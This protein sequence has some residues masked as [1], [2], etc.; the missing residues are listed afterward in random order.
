MKILI[1][2]KISA[3][4]IE[5]LKDQPDFQVVEAF[6]SGV[7][8]LNSLA[9]DAAAIIVRSETKVTAEVIAE[10]HSLKV[11]AR[12][13][14]GVDN[15]DI[16]AATQRGIVVMNA[17]SGNTNATAELTFTH[18]LC[19][20]RP[21][22]RADASM[23][24]GHWERKAFSGS[25]LYGKT[26]GILGLGRVGS[27]VAERAKAFGMSVLA[28]DPY[29]A[30]ERGQALDVESVDI[31]QLV[32]RVDYI[33][34]H[35]PLTEKTRGLIDSSA[36]EKMKDGVRLINCARGG[37]VV[38]ADLISA[39][40][41]GKIASAGLDVYEEEPVPQDSELLALPNL[42]LTPHLGASTRE[43]QDSVGLEVARGVADLLKEGIIRNALNMSS[44]DAGV[45]KIL[46]PYL[47]LGEKLGLILQQ[48]VSPHVQKMRITFWGKI[49]EQ[50]TL[51]LTRSIQRGYLRNISGENVND[52][53]A[54]HFMKR[55][56]IKVIV[57]QSSSECDFTELVRVE[58]V[59]PDKKLTSI[60]GTLV[61][62]KQVPRIVRLNG[63]DVESGLEGSLLILEN[64]DMP[65]MV[66]MVGTVLGRETVN[67]AGM[68][69]S[70]NTL[71]G[72][73]LTIL[74]LDSSPGEKALCEIASHEAIKETHLVD[75]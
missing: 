37:I 55:L 19:A 66:G 41:S 61:G 54:P 35:M 17:P 39:L 46:G 48:I 24:Q 25:E 43:A 32:E 14:V 69:L 15:V 21:I 10:A 2:D 70:R 45:L 58:A 23:K 56:G 72:L 73:A 1:A 26:L 68:S 51:P 64:E 8:R 67:I 52:V 74:Q 59:G 47:E 7:D 57:T 6:G 71:G 33:S 30:P 34:I 60:E 9:S 31:E 13:G 18:M 5:Y 4:G 27:I 22:C 75:F 3:A 36:I 40:K 49:I 42:V 20:A 63:R 38:E 11:I 44:V 29:L 28:Y 50:D 65:G 12:A 62:K 53:N 16:D